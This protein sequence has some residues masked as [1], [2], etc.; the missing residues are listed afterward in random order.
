MRLN[1]RLLAGIVLV[2]AMALS[3]QAKPK[4]DADDESTPAHKPGKLSHLMFFHKSGG[5]KRAA[6]ETKPAAS[7]T[8]MKKHTDGFPEAVKKDA[9]YQ[10]QNDQGWANDAWKTARNKD[11]FKQGDSN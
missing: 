4:A 5:S 11:S 10:P 3:V 7:T 2:S 9:K 8:M 6:S 1:Q